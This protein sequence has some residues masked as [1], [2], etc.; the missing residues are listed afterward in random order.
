M[1]WQ[2]PNNMEDLA[3]LPQDSDK[4]HLSMLGTVLTDKDLDNLPCTITTLVLTGCKHLTDLSRLTKYKNLISVKCE[5][6]MGLTQEGIHALQ[7]ALPG[8]R[9]DT[10]GCWQ[11]RFTNPDV[12]RLFNQV[13][14][15]AIHG[16]PLFT[17]S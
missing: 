4:V 9:V 2:H 6:C 12:M 1:T 5:N 11:L 3:E 14:L 7:K 8:L 13:L 15:E 16:A 10:W 17:E